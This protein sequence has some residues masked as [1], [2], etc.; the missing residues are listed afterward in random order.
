[1]TFFKKEMTFFK[2]EIFDE[3][4]NNPLIK[5]YLDENNLLLY[6]LNDFKSLSKNMRIKDLVDYMYSDLCKIINKKYIE[7][8]LIQA[9]KKNKYFDII[10]LMDKTI[11]SK[12]D[13]V[14]LKYIRGFLISQLGECEDYPNAYVLNLICSQKSA[15]LLGAYLYTIKNT[16]NKDQIG[17][18]ELAGSHT[19]LQALCAYNKFGFR[20][21]KSNKECFKNNMTM[22]VDLNLYSNEQI[23]NTVVSGKS[24]DEKIILDLCSKY[25]IKSN[26]NIDIKNKIKLLKIQK[27]IA[28]LY[29]NN[30]NSDYIDDDD[31]VNIKI[32]EKID[33]YKNIFD[34]IKNDYNRSQT[35]NSQTKN[36]QTKISQTKKSRKDTEGVEK[37][38]NV[39]NNSIVELES[40]ENSQKGILSTILR[41][42]R[43][44]KKRIKKYTRRKIN[45]YTIN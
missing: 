26:M 15:P 12:K 8:V 38:T 32:K 33:L 3:Y 23:I 24:I 10:F 18:L 31:G 29:D 21:D 5:N 13:N 36:S 7:E 14:K 37:I 22:T 20:P 9:I 42:I 28:K 39:N 40:N 27:E 6:D 16:K 17:I 4:K 1:M 43:K 11:L 34:N 19:N 35:K 30:Y 45:K 44:I 25:A 41:P 2:K